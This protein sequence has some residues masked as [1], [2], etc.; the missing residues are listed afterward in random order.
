MLDKNIFRDAR[1]LQLFCY[2]GLLPARAY[3]VGS[4]KNLMCV[5]P[6][7]SVVRRRPS[8]SSAPFLIDFGSR[9]ESNLLAWMVF[10]GYGK[11][12]ERDASITKGVFGQN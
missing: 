11:G 10:S 2:N 8:S 9:F 3:C 5:R 12:P 7:S 1:A 4:L 6:S